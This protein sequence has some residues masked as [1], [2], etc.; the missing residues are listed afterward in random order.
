L[1]ITGWEGAARHVARR[2]EAA[3]GILRDAGALRLGQRVGAAWEKGRFHGPSLRDGLLDAGALVETLETA[4]SWSGLGTLYG[5]V[6]AALHE[7]LAAYGTP[8]LLLCHLSHVYPTGASLYFTVMAVRD[9]AAPEAQWGAAK[10]AAGD[11][12]AAH[13]ATIT[14]HHAVGTEHLPWMRDEI[15][16]LGTAA[17]RAVKQCLDP[18]GIL[19][20]GKLLPP[21]LRSPL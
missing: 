13:R 11:A 6:R 4:A 2:R 7:S 18:N 8:P 19:N 5:A 1:L 17:L 10:R 14:H 15:G 9:D 21:R 3:G 12:I 16:D 20:P